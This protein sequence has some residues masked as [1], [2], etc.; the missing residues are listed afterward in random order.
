[1]RT[2]SVRLFDE[3]IFITAL[4]ETFYSG[5]VWAKDEPVNFSESRSEFIEGLHLNIITTPPFT[6]NGI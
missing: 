5:G 6:V 1:M 2:A 3:K 4:N